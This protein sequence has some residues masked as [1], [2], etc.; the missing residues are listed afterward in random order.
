MQIISKRI[1]A[2]LISAGLRGTCVQYKQYLSKEVS[3]DERGHF[4]IYTYNVHIPE[5]ICINK[6]DHW[7]ISMVNAKIQDFNNICNKRIKIAIVQLKPL[8]WSSGSDTQL[9]IKFKL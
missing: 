7:D 9:I 2:C 8:T 5:C 1:E 3:C 6:R 4:V